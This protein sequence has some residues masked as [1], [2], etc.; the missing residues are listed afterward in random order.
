M[1]IGL[2]FAGADP[3][4]VVSSTD[5]ITDL[6]SGLPI[7]LHL[8]GRRLSTMQFT[9]PTADTFAADRDDIA[10][11]RAVAEDLEVVQRYTRQRFP[12]PVEVTGLDRANLRF[13]RLLIDG[14]CVVL[15]GMHQ[16][17]L[18][19]NGSS[20]EGLLSMMRGPVQLFSTRD[21]FVWPIF[22][23]ELRL[24][25]HNVLAPQV[26]AVDGEDA[27]AALEA[28]EG[29]GRELVMKTLR[30]L[31][32]WYMLH[33]HWPTDGDTP[34]RPTSWGLAGIDDPPDVEMYAEGADRQ[35]ST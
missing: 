28:G 3:R 24:G 23:R 6:Q 13:L 33:E 7:E 29:E 32:F 11:F 2:D 30:G 15:P 27:I 22:G 21:E 12:M 17:T 34:I 25:P 8:D 26:A 4:D 1:N 14:K 20:D 16:L 9:S 35:V 5:L 10:M 19:L 18:T 31:G